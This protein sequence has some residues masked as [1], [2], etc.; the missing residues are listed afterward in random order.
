MDRETRIK[1]I[2]A[3]R[4]A[5]EEALAAI[6]SDPAASESVRQRAQTA[7]DALA[8]AFRP[9]EGEAGGGPPGV[10]RSGQVVIAGSRPNVRG[11]GSHYS[12]TKS[13]GRHVKTGAEIRPQFLG[14]AA[15]ETP[16]QLE[17]AK[18]GSYIKLLARKTPGLSPFV[19]WTEHDEA[20]W[21]ETLNA[22]S[23]CGLCGGEWQ[24]GLRGAQV[25]A[26]LLDDSASGGAYLSPEWFDLL[27]IV[28]PLLHSELLPYVQVVD[29]PRGS[30][31]E[32]ASVSTPSVTWGHGEGSEQTAF[33][34]TGLVS[35]TSNSIH[36]VACYLTVGQDMLA[37]SA[38]SLGNLL[39][40]LLAERM[41]YE[42]DRVVAVGD[43]VTE[44]E[45]IFSASGAQVVSAANGTSG[46]ITIGD[47]E[48]LI[49]SCPKQY[50]AA[51]L[52][53]SFICTDEGYRRCR[54]V[55]VG[56]SD[57]RRVLG[58][59]EQSYK[60]LEFPAR[61]CNSISEGS[62][63]FFPLAKYRLYRRAGVSSRWSTEGDTLM[64][65]NLA[66]LSVRGRF[67][68]CV[69][70]ANCLAKLTDGPTTG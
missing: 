12:T 69:T 17:T 67:G 39:V 70:D 52:N 5:A 45:G 2:L 53:P 50:R 49:F 48:T 24:R 14:G 7:A 65:S 62:M 47:L 57:Q 40:S 1:N 43:G 25:K 51:A 4:C 33:D 9:D 54:S 68:G 3:N 32:G 58:M 34:S 64:R 59:D 22:D 8:K 30:A 60:L 63:A 37:D 26:A 41:S 18:F 55:P 11:V 38:V 20:L 16:S 66:I 23:W 42:L 29:V 56:T 21:Q 35:Q 28:F 61:I 46:P 36:P 15:V 6:T 44:P 31:V 13:V 19:Q 27:T 10:S